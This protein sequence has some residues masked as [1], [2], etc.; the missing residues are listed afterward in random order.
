MRIL[1]ICLLIFLALPACVP[2][3]SQP[4]ADRSDS[5]Q[6]A[7]FMQDLPNV[8]N[9]LMDRTGDMYATLER[10]RGEGQL[11]RIRDRRVEVLV[12][13]LHRPD[14]L[15]SGEGLLFVTE[16]VKK[17]RVLSYHL[18]SGETRVVA[19]ELRMPEGI[20]VMNDGNL[21]VSEDRKDG[22][23]L[24]LSMSGER[25]T[26]LQGLNRPEG[27]CRDRVGVLYIAITA[28][29]TIIRLDG[30]H[31]TVLISGLNEPDQVECAEDGSI[32]ITEDASPGRLLRYQSGRLELIRAMLDYPQGITF[33]PGTSVYVAEQKKG[34]ILHLWQKP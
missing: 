16:E 14:G 19:Q 8:D 22:T 20:E 28:D 4:F 32:W 25:K 11:V 26:L 30:K 7:V 21:V 3:T 34:R 23:V 9:I 27:L 2:V 24:L 29:G 15:A 17:G 12:E 33:G 6:Q 10:S 31:A 13:G 18:H 1:F 5:W